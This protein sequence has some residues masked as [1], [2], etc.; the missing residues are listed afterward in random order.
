MISFLNISKSC[1]IFSENCEA[2]WT[3]SFR[4]GKLVAIHGREKLLQLPRPRRSKTV[5]NTATSARLLSNFVGLLKN[6]HRETASSGYQ[7]RA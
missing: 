1:D 4:S 5:V 7:I 3:E 2:V 6:A